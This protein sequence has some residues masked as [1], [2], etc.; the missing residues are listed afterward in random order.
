M[1]FFCQLGTKLGVAF[2][3][4]RVDRIDRVVDAEAKQLC[5]EAKQLF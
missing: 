5:A 1:L 2:T 4:V 3:G